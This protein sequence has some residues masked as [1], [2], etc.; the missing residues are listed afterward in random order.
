[1]AIKHK[2]HDYAEKLDRKHIRNKLASLLTCAVCLVTAT[3]QRRCR[4]ISTAESGDGTLSGS[5]LQQRPEDMGTDCA[6]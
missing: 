6:P 1:M 2:W 4:A 3:I 5:E